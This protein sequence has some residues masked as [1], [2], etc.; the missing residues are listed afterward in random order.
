MEDTNALSGEAA[1][2][3]L[4]VGNAFFPLGYMAAAI[5]LVATAM[6]IART[7]VLPRWLAIA[8]LVVAVGV[9]VPIVQWPVFV[10][11]FPA[12]V[13]ACS[14]LL[15]RRDAT[16]TVRVGAAAVAA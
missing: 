5:P 3:L 4:H 6:V 8:S 10:F 12:W 16:A 1:Q 7:R 2:A 15:V 11:L 14:L 9:L 13:V